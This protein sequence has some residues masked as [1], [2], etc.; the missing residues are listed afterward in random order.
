[1]STLRPGWVWEDPAIVKA[2]PINGLR[3]I[4]NERSNGLIERILRQVDG[5]PGWPIIRHI[6][7]GIRD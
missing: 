2:M 4:F 6:R 1:V 5:M 3:S 7:A